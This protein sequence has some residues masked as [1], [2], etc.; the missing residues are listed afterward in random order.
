MQVRGAAAAH[1]HSLLSPSSS[2]RTTRPPP[3]ASPTLVVVRLEESSPASPKGSSHPDIRFLSPP[4]L[5]FP[6]LLCFRGGG[7]ERDEG[8]RTGK[9]ED[10]K[11]EEEEE[12]H[13]SFLLHAAGVLV[14]NPPPWPPWLHF[15]VP[16]HHLC[17]RPP[18]PMSPFYLARGASKVRPVPSLGS[19]FHSCFSIGPGRGLIVVEKA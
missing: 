5:P 18:A 14:L 8:R 19:W 4:S 10:D 9:E 12:H 11:E 2:P 7:E 16:S 1:A 13:P 15:R 3:P 17:R 6:F